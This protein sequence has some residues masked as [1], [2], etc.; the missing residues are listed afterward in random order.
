MMD[1]WTSTAFVGVG[2]G[3]QPAAGPGYEPGLQ[4]GQHR[5]CLAHGQAVPAP[6]PFLVKVNLG[7]SY[8]IPRALAALV[9]KLNA[10]NLTSVRQTVDATGLG[11]LLSKENISVCLQTSGTADRHSATAR[12]SFFFIRLSS[13]SSSQRDQQVTLGSGLL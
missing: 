10:R 4:V 1:G 7:G 3:L 5:S 2:V 6:S 13:G 12:G 11:F 9:S 8:V